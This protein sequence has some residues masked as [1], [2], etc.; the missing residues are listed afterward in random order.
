MSERWLRPG[1]PGY[2]RLPNSWKPLR[3]R[4]GEKL[5]RGLEQL[6]NSQGWEA[7]AFLLTVPTFSEHLHLSLHL[8]A[9]EGK[10]PGGTQVQFWPPVHTAAK[11]SFLTTP[12]AGSQAGGPEQQL[13]GLL[14]SVLP[15][16][17]RVVWLVP[18]L[19]KY[20]TDHAGRG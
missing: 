11:P 20:A 2:T 5:R 6:A 15:E 10:R 7:L 16:A 19:P 9:T 14:D 8:A 17:R 13:G 4:Q 12:R 1:K 3:L 18:P